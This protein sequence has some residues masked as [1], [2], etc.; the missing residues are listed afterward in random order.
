MVTHVAGCEACQEFESQLPR[1]KSLVRPAQ[2]RI[3]QP[4]PEALLLL[5]SQ[6]RD[7]SPGP[8]PRGLLS[9]TTVWRRGLR[10]RRIGAWVGAMVPGTLALLLLLGVAASGHA[11]LAPSLTANGCIVFFLHHHVWPGF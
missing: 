8:V 5:L 7:R 1:L 2:I 6:V 9:R 3:A 11:H 4:L 10:W